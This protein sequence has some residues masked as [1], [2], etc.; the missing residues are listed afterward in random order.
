MLER[1]SDGE[2]HRNARTESE[3]VSERGAQPTK[4]SVDNDEAI[5]DFG[6][7]LV[8]PGPYKFAQMPARRRAFE[9]NGSVAGL[10][11]HAH[12][13]ARTEV[14]QRSRR[15]GFTGAAQGYLQDDGIAV[16]R[17]EAEDAA[18]RFHDVAAEHD[19]PAPRIVDEPAQ[20]IHRAE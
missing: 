16:T 15:R 18:R 4:N 10:L 17:T 2:D 11:E 14:S 19:V 12:G 7:A 8:R 5:E 6:R 3:Q 1:S 20:L 9:Q 13:R